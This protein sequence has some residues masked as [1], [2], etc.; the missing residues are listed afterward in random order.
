MNIE[1]N[2]PSRRSAIRSL[3]IGLTGI[4]SVSGIAIASKQDTRK[5]TTV[6]RHGEP[7][8]TKKVPQSWYDHYKRATKLTRQTQSAFVESP[9]VT[10]IGMG[11]QKRTVG[12]RRGFQIIV[13]AMSGA[14]TAAIPNEINGIPIK[15]EELSEKPEF[16]CV[17]RGSFS[18]TPAGVHVGEFD[19]SRTGGT[20]GAHVYNSNGNLRTLTANHVLGDE[21]TDNSGKT[22]YQGNTT[23]GNVEGTNEEAD[24]ALINPSRGTNSEILEADDDRYELYAHRTEDGIADLISSGSTV[25]STGTA[26]GTTSGPIKQMHV[27]SLDN[28][29]VGFFG[30]GVITNADAADG[31]SG[32]PVYNIEYISPDVRAVFIHMNNLKEGTDAGDVPKCGSGGSSTVTARSDVRGQ[33]FYYLHNQFGLDIA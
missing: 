19:N 26:T 24:T 20:I 25:K 13:R 16:A 31:D 8:K 23:F 32:G 11:S 4:T 7:I 28:S 17:H 22:A 2:N 29:C 30:H 5:I 33:S 21:C 15:I 12:G 3:S 27:G 1:N 9:G 10:S 6:K 18:P 14:N